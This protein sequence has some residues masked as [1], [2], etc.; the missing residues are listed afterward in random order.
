MLFPL[1]Y[2]LFLFLPLHSSLAGLSL[3]CRSSWY[4]IPLLIHSSQGWEVFWLISASI[5]RPLAG[6]VS[7]WL[8]LILSST[9]HSA[10]LWRRCSK[11]IQRMLG[12]ISETGY[13]FNQK[14]SLTFSLRDFSSWQEI[15]KNL[16]WNSQ[17]GGRPEATC[18]SKHIHFIWFKCG[19]HWW[20][21]FWVNVMT[22]ALELLGGGATLLWV[23]NC[24]VRIFSP[25]PLF[26][27]GL[28]C[29]SY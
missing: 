22:V 11:D 3:C 9:Q 12:C 7:V 18:G 2:F 29:T 1:R 24:G 15:Q 13:K 16:Y 17:E 10:W 14:V 4:Q 19:T 5:C 6:P 20:Q 21:W 28:S 8:T 25:V 26:L 27:R 23:H